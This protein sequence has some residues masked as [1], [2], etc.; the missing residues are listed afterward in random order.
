MVK[1]LKERPLDLIYVIFFAIHIP[2]F[3]LVDSQTLYPDGWRPLAN[4][5][6]EQFNDPN[7]GGALGEWKAG[8]WTWIWF[9]SFLWLEALFQLP[10]FFLGIINLKNG[11]RPFGRK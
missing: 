1:P 8:A 9:R 11:T 6:L 2:A 10:M 7:I 5:Y 3:F 4:W